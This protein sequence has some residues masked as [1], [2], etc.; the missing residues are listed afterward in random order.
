MKLFQYREDVS[1]SEIRHYKDN[2]AHGKWSYYEDDGKNVQ[3]ICTYENSF[4]QEC[5]QF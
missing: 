3:R 4:L 2:L 5:F 1:L